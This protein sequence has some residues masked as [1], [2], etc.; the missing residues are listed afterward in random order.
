MAIFPTLTRH[1][2]LACTPEVHSFTSEKAHDPTIRSE[3]DGG[4]VKSRARFTRLPEKWNICYTWLSQANKNTIKDF[5]EARLIG[6]ESFTWT[7]P[8]DGISYTV[9][10]LGLVRYTPHAS[11]N[12]LWWTVEFELEEV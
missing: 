4:Y 10:F 12:Y 11:T 7:N 1:G 2:S 3:S 5:E 8:E 6:S 9:R